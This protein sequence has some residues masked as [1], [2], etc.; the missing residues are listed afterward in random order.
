MSAH[1]A[2]CELAICMCACLFTDIFGWVGVCLS[3]VYCSPFIEIAFLFLWAEFGFERKSTNNMN[4]ST[5]W[6]Y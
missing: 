5:V 6:N 4:K 3:C 2:P 1:D